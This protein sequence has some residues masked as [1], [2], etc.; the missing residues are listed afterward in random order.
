VVAWGDTTTIAERVR[1][2]HDAG[3]N[4]VCV[5]VWWPTAPRG[6]PSTPT[7][8]SPRHYPAAEPSRSGRRMEA[9]TL[10]RI[11][12]RFSVTSTTMRSSTRGGPR[13]ARCP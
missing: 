10:G 12:N 5:Q 3:A 6:S 9:T 2:F 1:A 4:H 8:N 7:G 13:D 11:G